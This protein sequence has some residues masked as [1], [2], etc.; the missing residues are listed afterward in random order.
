MPDKTFF[1]LDILPARKGDCLLLHYGTEDAPR[2]W[3]VDGGPSQVYQPALR[4]RLEDTRVARGL[5]GG[6]ALRIDLLMVSHLD[7]DH[8][9]GILEFAGELKDDAEGHAPLFAKVDNIWHNVFDDIIGNTPGQMQS[10]SDGLAS[11]GGSVPDGMDHDI[12][13]V[14]TS[15][16][17]GHEL[18]GYAEF[19]QARF[20]DWQLNGGF[21]DLVMMEADDDPAV[22]RFPGLRITILGPRKTELEKLQKKWDKFLRD[23]NLGRSSAEAALAAF[24]RDRSVS[25]LASIVVLVECD[26]K[27]MLLTGDALGE[28]ILDALEA[29]GLAYDT[30]PLCVDILKIQHHGSNRNSS[31]EFFR[32]VR[33]KH[34]VFSGDGEHGNPE[35]ATVEM[36]L[37]ER[38]GDAITLHFSTPLD[39]IDA[40][41]KS[42]AIGDGHAWDDATSA[43][44]SLLDAAQAGGAPIMVREPENRRG[45]R[46]DLLDPV[47]V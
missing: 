12:A 34:Y 31:R 19:F 8:I 15:V 22:T 6:H 17:Q 47:A 27:S 26:G 23:N 35:R 40:K 2:L 28:K 13:A 43:L 45:L 18:R 20:D 37:D 38:G 39:E 21:D 42:E 9:K 16:R 32:R 10:A 3:I 5:A 30:V 11:M 25:N 46:I 41:R 14:F 4:P 36:L 29:R 24:G 7:D 44:K 1:S 33:A